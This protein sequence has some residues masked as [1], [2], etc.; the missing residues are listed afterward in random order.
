MP[1]TRKVE[2]HHS[3]LTLGK[4]EKASSAHK[5]A[6]KKIEE[7][8]ASLALDSD[9]MNGK[10]EMQT[11]TVATITA[12]RGG[13]VDAP[14]FSTTLK[15]ALGGDWP[16]P[17]KEFRDGRMMVTCKSPAEAREMERS[18]EVH[19][20][21]FSFKCEPWT[22]DLWRVD[23]ADG[24]VRWLEVR[25]LPCHCWNRDS[26]GR[27]LKLVGD[28]IY[29]DR[30]GGSYV[31]DIRVAVRIRQ[32]RSMPFIIWTNI[33][34]R[35]YR[36]L[37]GLERGEPPLPWGDGES[38]RI[39][40]ELDMGAAGTSNGHR[41]Q[42]KKKTKKKEEEG[43]G[44]N[45]TDTGKEGRW[46]VKE[47]TATT[48]QKRDMAGDTHCNDEALRTGPASTQD[49]SMG[50]A[51]R[52]ERS[53][54]ADFQAS[55]PRPPG[56]QA[57]VSNSQALNVGE[58][59]TLHEESIT[60]PCIVPVEVNRAHSLQTSNRSEPNREPSSKAQPSTDATNRDGPDVNSGP[61]VQYTR[62][63]GKEPMEGPPIMDPMRD[64]RL[65]PLF[66]NTDLDMGALHQPTDGPA[67]MNVIEM[68]TSKNGP[69][70]NYQQGYNQDHNL[71]EYEANAQQGSMQGPLLPISTNPINPNPIVNPPGLQNLN[72]QA[73][74]ILDLI[75]HGIIDLN[76]TIPK[77]M[78]GGWNLI[79]NATWNNTP[80]LQGEVPDLSDERKTGQKPR[81]E[82]KSTK[83]GKHKNMGEPSRPRG[84]PKKIPPVKDQGK[85]TTP[86]T[87]KRKER[88]DPQ[89]LLETARSIRAPGRTGGAAMAAEKSGSGGA[90]GG[91]VEGGQDPDP[92]V[93]EAAEGDAKADPGVD[94]GRVRED[95][96]GVGELGDGGRS[97]WGGV[98]DG[99]GEGVLR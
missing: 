78:N 63:P 58:K 86:T 70:S 52:P 71:N 91:G 85:A 8:H 66:N 17:A 61:E 69:N 39:T 67:P 11:F 36:V 97:V 90:W 89:G 64:N 98:W 2:E 59:E 27:V 46:S 42:Q 54:R 6:T 50:T 80:N 87:K 4:V 16:W 53:C 20:Q 57:H 3:S 62:R 33:G 96:A 34:T 18:G 48:G 47:K 7:H 75:N 1:E 65:S 84:R 35:K 82:P 13:W 60:I 43:G 26:A 49:R 25:R 40:D 55:V 29:I 10:E 51:M 92:G 81:E 74:H 14:K 5:P 28:L 68:N 56:L 15:T 88:I 72:P 32:G 93:A 83:Q 41:A 12:I 21:P 77:F 95:D 45:A 99:A 31:E 22:P 9:M 37:V 76:N 30:R 23:R 24:Q 19:L 44:T 94:P 73:L 38:G 79:S